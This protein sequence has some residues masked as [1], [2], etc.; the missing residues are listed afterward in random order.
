MT[1]FEA[2]YGRSY[3]IPINWSDTVNRVLIG[4]DMLAEM[5]Y[6]MQVIKNNLKEAKDMQKSYENQHR[7]FKDFRVR[8]KLYL[9]IKPK[10]SSLRIGSC[11]KLAPQFCVP[12]NILERI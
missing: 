6:K 10:K 8:E 2:L 11:S 5:E 12:F 1:P 7:L 9:H 3:N 4:L